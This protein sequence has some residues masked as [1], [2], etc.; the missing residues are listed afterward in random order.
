RE[1]R[2]LLL[3]LLGWSSRLAA[4]YHQ[5]RDE[6]G[7]DRGNQG[8]YKSPP[9]SQSP[10]SH[11]KPVLAQNI[12]DPK[13]QLREKLKAQG[14]DVSVGALLQATVVEKKSSKKKEVVYRVDT[15]EFIEAEQKRY[16]KIPD[17]GLVWV[18]IKDDELKHVKFK[19]LA[20]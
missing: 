8:Q 7:H 1:D 14:Q 9:E 16:D 10:H 18:E 15:I 12:A 13:Q 6:R 17:S 4:F 20:D 19:K 5:S 11:Q 3:Q 2:D